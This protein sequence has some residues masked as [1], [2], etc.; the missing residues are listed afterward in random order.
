M[1]SKKKIHLEAI[2]VKSFVTSLANDEKTKIKGGFI[3]LS[4][5]PICTDHQTETCQCTDT[6][7]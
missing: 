7:P 3:K 6:C 1:K 5:P 4:E 2:N